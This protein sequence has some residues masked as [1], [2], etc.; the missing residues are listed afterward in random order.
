M[1]PRRAVPEGYV[2]ETIIEKLQ[3]SFDL[4]CNECLP[5][6]SEIMS[7]AARIVILSLHVHLTDGDP[8]AT[9]PEIRARLDKFGEQLAD[10]VQS[11]LDEPKS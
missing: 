5:I 10:L 11:A 3:S 1:K 4:V 6:G 2:G 7:A 9:T 8:A